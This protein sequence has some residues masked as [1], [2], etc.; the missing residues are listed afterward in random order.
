MDNK[1]DSATTA[2]QQLQGN[3]TLHLLWAV[4]KH[5]LTAKT[6]NGS[7]NKQSTMLMSVRCAS[8]PKKNQTENKNLA[9]FS[10]RRNLIRTF[11]GTCTLVG[12]ANFVMWNLIMLMAREANLLMS[13]KIQKKSL[14]KTAYPKWIH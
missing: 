14:Q 1:S 9:F 13:D 2:Q 10:K 3:Q 6:Q 12:F 11:F 4:K 5:N 8:K 7:K